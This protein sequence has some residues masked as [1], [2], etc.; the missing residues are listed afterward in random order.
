MIIDTG[1]LPSQAV[2]VVSL[3][4]RKERMR[5]HVTRI[6][7]LWAEREALAKG[8][9]T[10]ANE[11]KRADLMREIMKLALALG[12]AKLEHR[13]VVIEDERVAALVNRLM[14]RIAALARRQAAE[15]AAAIGRWQDLPDRTPANDPLNA[16]ESWVEDYRRR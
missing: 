4:P 3:A 6:I 7:N 5:V 15:K 11:R 2:N 14:P 8:P 9:K 16:G 13:E 12:R 1:T 10:L